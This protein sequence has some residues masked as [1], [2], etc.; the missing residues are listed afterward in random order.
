MFFL[1]NDKQKIQIYKDMIRFKIA[2]PAIIAMGK[3]EKSIKA[4]LFSL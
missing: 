1:N 3:I 2:L 4:N